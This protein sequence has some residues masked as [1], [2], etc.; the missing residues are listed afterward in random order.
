MPGTAVEMLISEASTNGV[1]GQ[2]MGMLNATADIIHSVRNETEESVQKKYRPGNK[3]K[4]RVLFKLPD[5]DSD[6]TKIGVSLLDHVV[7][8]SPRTSAEEKVIRDPLELLPLSSFVD[9]AKVV[10]VQPGIGLFMDI[11]IRG[12][13]GFAHISRLAD[14]KI[15][16]LLATTGAFREGSVHR[17]RVIGYNAMDGLFLLSLEPKIL[18]QPFLRIEDVEVG[19]IVQGKVDKLILGPKG[20]TG[21]LINLAEG[22]TGLVPETHMADVYLQNP[23]KK[24]REGA[25]VKARVLSTDPDKRQLRL[26]LKKTLVNSD[27]SVWKNY[28][29]ISVGDQSQGSIVN[30]LPTGAVVSSTAMCELSY[31]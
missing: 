17:A 24:F 16:T 10:K 27:A 21:V 2:V 23:E 3:A 29:Q 7:S 6:S 25:P 31:L 1:I 13:Q 20:V 8:L 11:A 22:I 28:K 14:T 15:E 5:S 9:Q 12:I 26:T 19:S 4:A 18:A 30:I